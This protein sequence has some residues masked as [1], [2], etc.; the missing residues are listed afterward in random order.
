MTFGASARKQRKPENQRV[1]G[2]RPNR[3]GRPAGRVVGDLFKPPIRSS[4]APGCSLERDFPVR[5]SDPPLSATV[6]LL[7]Q[8]TRGDGPQTA[9]SDR[10]PGALRAPMRRYLQ[11]HSIGAAPRRKGRK[12]SWRR[13]CGSPGLTSARPDFLVVGR[14]GSASPQVRGSATRR[15]LTRSPSRLPPR[16]ITAA[17]A[18]I[19]NSTSDAV[20]RPS[21]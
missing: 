3:C 13:R 19:P 12:R 6:W 18:P 17:S 21:R 16:A 14:T 11:G 20:R 2:R 10:T 9:G 7:E 8:V 4:H 15:A 1:G 5:A